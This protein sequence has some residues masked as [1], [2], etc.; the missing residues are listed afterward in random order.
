MNALIVGAGIGGPVAALWLQRLGLEVSLVEARPSPALT[1]GAFLGV[2]PNG[3]NAIAPLGLAERIAR[4]G[5]RCEGFQF[6]NSAGHGIGEIDRSQDA[7]HFGWPLT[8]IR[9]ADLHLVLHEACNERGIATRFGHRLLGL[10]QRADHITAT[11]AD[12]NTLDADILIGCDGLRSRVRALG[13][14]DAPQPTATGLLDFGGFARVEALPLPQGRNVM[15]F[16]RRAFFGAF[17]TPM[18]ETWWF[19]NGPTPIRELSPEQHRQRMLELHADDPDWIAHC[20]RATS[21]ILGPWPLHELVA[22]PRWSS[23]RLCLLGDAA[24]AMSPSAGQGAAMAMEDALVLTQCLRDLPDPPRAFARFE[25]LRRPRVD[26]IFRAAQRNSNNKAL[27]PV[28][29]WFRDRILPRVLPAAGRAQSDSY[30]HR[31]HWEDRV[32]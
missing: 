31:L 20:I 19:H 25:A 27:G 16:G 1:E 18:G 5:L 4:R 21:Q 12:G 2:T 29:A 13:I 23:G 22:M 30:A 15:V 3:M 24:H 32:V 8:M 14:P 17:T 26:A 7:E 6:L 11:F 28:A 9:R 10:T